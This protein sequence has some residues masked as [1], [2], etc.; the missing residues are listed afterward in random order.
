MEHKNY[1]TPS[2]YI[3]KEIFEPKGV[4]YSKKCRKRELRV[5]NKT[6]T[7]K[8]SIYSNGRIIPQTRVCAS[9]RTEISAYLSKEDE[10]PRQ[11]TV[12]I[13][14]NGDT[15]TMMKAYPPCKEDRG[16]HHRS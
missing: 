6:L 11:I 8:I 9:K 1:L 12:Y 5:V 10:K 16:A 13:L 7:D 15:P 4:C 3:C 2:I 14:K